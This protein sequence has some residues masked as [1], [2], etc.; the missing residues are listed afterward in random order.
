MFTAPCSVNPPLT[1]KRETIILCGH[2]LFLVGEFF[3]LPDKSFQYNNWAM[4]EP[5]GQY[6]KEGAG[7][8]CVVMSTLDLPGK[9]MDTDCR[10]SKP[11]VCKI[12]KG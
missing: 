8:N 4:N 9:W 11:F 3:M 6:L 12:Q 2:Y 7:H 10:D 1:H 5:D